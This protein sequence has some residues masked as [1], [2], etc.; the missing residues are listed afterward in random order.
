MLDAVDK[1]AEHKVKVTNLLIDDNWQSIDYAGHGQFQ[2][3]WVEFEAE[4]KSF[5]NGLKSMI[6]QIRDRHPH[7]QHIAVWHALLGDSSLCSPRYV[8]HIDHLQGTGVGFHPMASWRE[9]TRPSR[10]AEKT[11]SGTISPLTAK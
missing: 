7:I 4:K 3:G 6:S 9:T 10:W 1:L 2:H 11:L 8:S 5:P